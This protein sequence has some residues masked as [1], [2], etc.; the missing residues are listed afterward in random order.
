MVLYAVL[1]VSTSRNEHGE[2]RLLIANLDA[3]PYLKQHV[4]SSFRSHTNEDERYVS[5]VVITMSG[6]EFPALDSIIKGVAGPAGALRQ[7]VLTS[8]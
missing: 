5:R 4:L 8:I 7:A 6:F 3:P 2:D 1:T